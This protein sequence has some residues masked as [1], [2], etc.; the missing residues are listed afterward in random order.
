MKIGENQLATTQDPGMDLDNLEGRHILVVEDDYFVAEALTGF[1]RLCG[2][3]V[4]GPV[5]TL[6]AALELA[7]Q[8]EPIEFAILDINLDGTRVF[9]V[10]DVLIAR[11][12]P[13]AFLT[14][15][16][17]PYLPERYSALPVISKPF[18]P[19][20][21]FRALRVTLPD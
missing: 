20:D 16:D 9:P 13:I 1:L 6:E 15:Y 17:R 21:I 12:V 7:R 3:R 19:A 4:V 5:A 14:G 8:A 2:A 18:L 10:A 11:G